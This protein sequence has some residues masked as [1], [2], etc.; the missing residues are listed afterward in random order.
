MKNCLPF[1]INRND[2]FFG[3]IHWHLFK[4]FNIKRT[5][6]CGRTKN[7]A[8]LCCVLLPNEENSYIIN[9]DFTHEIRCKVCNSIHISSNHYV[10]FDDAQ[11]DW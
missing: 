5:I 3:K 10:D 2:N 6:P 1:E 11:E 8:Y 4:I 7:N 9:D